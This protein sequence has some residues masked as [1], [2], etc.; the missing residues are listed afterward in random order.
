MSDEPSTPQSNMSSTPF[1][2]RSLKLPTKKHKADKDHLPPS[3]KRLDAANMT[4]P[5]ALSGAA[6][7][8]DSKYV[9]GKYT[10]Q[11]MEDS[12]VNVL[13]DDTREVKGE[14]EETVHGETKL[15]YLD[16]RD[17]VVGN[18]DNLAVNG[19]QEIFVLGE[20]EATY[21]GKHEVSAPFEFETKLVEAGLTG[22]E[23]KFLGVGASVIGRESE[24]KIAG[25]KEALFES[26]M[27]GFHEE[28]HAHKGEAEALSDKAAVTADANARV[29]VLPDVG[30]G[31]P[32]R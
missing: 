4:S 3:F 14:Q 2:A 28:V 15:T 6:A 27:E 8:I 9:D 1:K 29:D 31:T 25:E 11:I 30:I 18:E 23:L 21:V 22:F 32:I 16:G 10:A 20:S 7:G 19:T 24:V 5:T 17:V 26:F 13:G 12:K